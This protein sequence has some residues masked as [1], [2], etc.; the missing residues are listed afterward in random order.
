MPQTLEAAIS[1]VE[2][3]LKDAVRVALT[4]TAAAVA[5]ASPLRTAAAAQ[6]GERRRTSEEEGKHKHINNSETRAVAQA[7]PENRDRNA[8][9]HGGALRGDSEG[10]VTGGAVG[11]T[12]MDYFD[13][14]GGETTAS[15]SAV[16][17]AAAEDVAVQ[18]ACAALTARLNSGE[19]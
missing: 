11:D 12:R 7:I 13:D 15:W 17:A 4:A 10:T 5:A 2:I 19:V 16:I 9:L 14:G 18:V 3:A 8:S 6:V 1:A